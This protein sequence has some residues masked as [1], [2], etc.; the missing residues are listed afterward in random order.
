M[1]K[2]EREKRRIKNALVDW[3]RKTPHKLLQIPLNVPF[4]AT[5]SF[6]QTQQFLVCLLVCLFVYLFVFIQEQQ[7]DNCGSFLFRG[8][9]RH[10]CFGCEKKSRVQ[11]CVTY[12]IR[13]CA[14]CYS[15]WLPRPV[16]KVAR[17]DASC[18]RPIKFVIGS[19]NSCAR[20]LELTWQ[21][22]IWTK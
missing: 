17:N 5:H 12:C 4:F 7:N 14:R 10:V 11:G 16:P 20:L 21:N 18:V 9:R 1:E 15:L 3:G 8:Y 22:L 6:T 13:S 19:L 2:I